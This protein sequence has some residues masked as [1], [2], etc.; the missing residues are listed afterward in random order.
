MAPPRDA[1][2]GADADADAFELRLD[3]LDELAADYLRSEGLVSEEA[4]ACV[5]CVSNR[6]VDGDDDDDDSGAPRCEPSGRR[7]QS[8]RPRTRTPTHTAR[9]CV[10]TLPTNKRTLRRA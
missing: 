5:V 7:Q 6:P 4:C 10:E 8:V 3:V 9:C 1:P 2:T